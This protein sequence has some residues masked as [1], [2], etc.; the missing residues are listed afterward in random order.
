MIQRRYLKTAVSIEEYQ[1][2]CQRADAEGLALAGY[3]RAALERDGERQT[4][5]QAMAAIHAAL[6]KSGQDGDTGNAVL[7]VVEPALHELLQLARLL[8]SHA[9]AQAAARI[10]AAVNQQYPNRKAMSQNCVAYFS[11]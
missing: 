9:N 11:R 7:A 6:P 5:A 4:I 2:I 1:G 3:F 8:A 10:T